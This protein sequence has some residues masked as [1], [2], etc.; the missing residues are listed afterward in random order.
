MRAPALLPLIA[1]LVTAAAPAPAQEAPTPTLTVTGEGRA[2]A[3]PD[4]AHLR[5]GVE[6]RAESAARALRETSDGTGRLIRTLA[7]AG[8]AERDIQTAAV[9]VRPV[10]ESHDR[11]GSEPPRIAGYAAANIVTARIADL[12]GLGAVLDRV[13][14]GGANRLEGLSFGLSD[15]A[16][17]LAEA[18]RDALAKARTAAETYAAA[19]GLALGPIRRI[20]DAAAENGPRAVPMAVMRAEASSVPVQPGEV[21]LTARVTVVWTLEPGE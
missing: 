6:A 3:A 7:E 17:A 13:V 5:I 12:D 9:T 4:E 1:L 20:A 11:S 19:A 8:V 15:P 21:E 16:P 18:R 10:Y 14:T 2:A